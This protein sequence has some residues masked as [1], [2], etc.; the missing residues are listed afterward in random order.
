MMAGVVLIITAMAHYDY[1]REAAEGEAVEGAAEAAGAAVERTKTC[2][3]AN[4]KKVIFA[5]KRQPY[6]I[7]IVS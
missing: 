5:A 3:D 4:R 2:L 1:V 7:L 6:G